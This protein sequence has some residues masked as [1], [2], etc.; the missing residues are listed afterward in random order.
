MAFRQGSVIRSRSSVSQVFS[1]S[2][3]WR[4]FF[5]A[6]NEVDQVLWRR[7]INGLKRGS[8]SFTPLLIRNKVAHPDRTQ[9]SV[10]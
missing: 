3:L 4:R 7:Q 1:R 8:D 9:L 6:T 5:F 2:G 10:L